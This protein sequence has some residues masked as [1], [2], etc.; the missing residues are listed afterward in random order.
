MP[1]KMSRNKGKKPAS[2]A[3]VILRTPPGHSVKE[4]LAQRMPLLKRVTA[5]AARE[6]FWQEWLCGH[7]PEPLRT[8][9][10]G[11]V[12]REGTLTIFAE[13]P[14]WSARL[15]YAV[16]ELEREMRAADPALNAV[17]VRVL[18]RGAAAR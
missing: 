4:L 10:C 6:R 2:R 17:R 15:R 3:S 14:A 13:S 8:R 7:I 18:P 11:I 9:I 5:R 12:E 16:L 1:K